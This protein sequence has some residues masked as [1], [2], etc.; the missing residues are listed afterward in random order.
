MQRRVHGCLFGNG[1]GNVFP[2]L[3]LWSLEGLEG[4][5]QGLEVPHAMRKCR[6]ARGWQKAGTPPAI[7]LL[8][9]DQVRADVFMKPHSICCVSKPHSQRHHLTSVLGEQEPSGKGVIAGRLQLKPTE[10]NKPTQGIA[11]EKLASLFSS[12]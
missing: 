1:Y 8:L 3:A 9:W 12:K 10:C 2:L 11:L 5:A 7:T 6:F 4:D